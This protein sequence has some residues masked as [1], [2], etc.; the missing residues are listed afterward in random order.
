MRAPQERADRL[1]HF[2]VPRQP[3][4]R[5][6]VA[7]VDFISLSDAEGH[8]KSIRNRYGLEARIFCRLLRQQ[9]NER[10]P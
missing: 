10:K 2:I 4:W 7:G 3:R 8:A 6:E 5:F 9:P 1:P